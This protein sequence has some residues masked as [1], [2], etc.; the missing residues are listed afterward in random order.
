MKS[1]RS[2]F[3]EIDDALLQDNFYKTRR[4]RCAEKIPVASNLQRCAIGAI[5][6]HNREK[7]IINWHFSRLC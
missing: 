7:S 2:V 3:A 1:D 6:V 5:I 4:T